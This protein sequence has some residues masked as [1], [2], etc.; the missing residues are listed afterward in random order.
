[1]RHL[2]HQD[3]ALILDLEVATEQHDLMSILFQLPE[4]YHIHGEPRNKVNSDHHL[5]VDI[6]ALEQ[7]HAMSFNVGHGPILKVNGSTNFCVKLRQCLVLPRHVICHP[8]VKDLV[9]ALSA[10]LVTELNEEFRLVEV[11]LCRC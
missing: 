7:D 3:L 4:T 11:N 10:L 5:V 9:C 1:M 6:L 2:H 8:R